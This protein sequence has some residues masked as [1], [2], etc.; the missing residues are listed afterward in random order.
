MAKIEKKERKKKAGMAIAGTMLIVG[1][2]VCRIK[3]II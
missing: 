1:K 3:S 2:K